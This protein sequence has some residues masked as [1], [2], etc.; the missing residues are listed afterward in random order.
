MNIIHHLRLFSLLLGTKQA[1]AR[2]EA[3]VA[4]SPTLLFPALHRPDHLVTSMY[5]LV[6]YIRLGYA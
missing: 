3:K 2:R 6:K 5:V 1:E 4:V